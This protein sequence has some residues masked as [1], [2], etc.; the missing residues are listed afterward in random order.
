[1][2]NLIVI[3]STLFLVDLITTPGKTIFVRELIKIFDTKIITIC[4]HAIDDDA[5]IESTAVFPKY[6]LNVS[7]RSRL[8][9]FNTA[10]FSQ[11]EYLI[12]TSI[13]NPGSFTN[14][15]FLKFY[16][17]TMR[18]SSLFFFVC[19]IENI[20]KKSANQIANEFNELETRHFRSNERNYPALK[21][22]SIVDPASALESTYYRIVCNNFCKQNQ[23]S[24]FP[25]FFDGN[26]N[27]LHCQLFHNANERLIM[28]PIL[29]CYMD[30]FKHFG[31][32]RH[33]CPYL[34]KSRSSNRFFCNADI[35]TIMWLSSQHNISFVIINRGNPAEVKT[36]DFG[37]GG[38]FVKGSTI[39]LRYD[40]NDDLA[41]SLYN[42][43]RAAYCVQNKPELLGPL[44]I[45]TWSEA[46]PAQ[47][48]LV[49]NTNFLC[50]FKSV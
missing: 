29:V 5:I 20:S 45:T 49:R 32:R 26:T 44:D 31:N 13:Q 10:K 11:P 39:K 41:L 18:H 35:M 24:G 16:N 38:Q 33:I 42:S 25:S 27:H 23:F 40:R 6:V 3:V 21:I 47:I 37:P 48:W 1:M 36:V 46:L 28:A 17:Q 15:V 2:A 7:F 14:H 22:I 34:E 43:R 30:F 9:L 8:S 4:L 50:D 12:I 19:H